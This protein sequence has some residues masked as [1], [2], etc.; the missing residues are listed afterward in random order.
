MQKEV[1]AYYAWKYQFMRH[2]EMHKH[3]R[4]LLE[5]YTRFA[6]ARDAEK[7]A[8]EKKVDEVNDVKAALLEA[9]RVLNELKVSGMGSGKKRGRSEEG[10]GGEDE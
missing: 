7:R 8:T 3:E 1:V 4:K 5:E 10:E 2:R 6:V 9:N